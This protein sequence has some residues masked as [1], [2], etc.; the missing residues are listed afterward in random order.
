M[1]EQIKIYP[2]AYADMKRKIAK[3]EALEKSGV[4]SWE[5]YTD[6]LRGWQYKADHEDLIAETIENIND[7]ITEANIY[8]PSERGAG[9]AVDCDEEAFA[10]FL[11]IFVEKYI[12]LEKRNGGCFIPALV[13]D[14]R[15]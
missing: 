11:K 9:Y 13:Q 5:N 6:A 8:E 3:L 2:W 15:R 14:S 10:K 4:E 1:S 7:V 12:E